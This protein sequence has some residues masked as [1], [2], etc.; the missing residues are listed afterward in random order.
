M[1][2]NYDVSLFHVTFPYILPPDVSLFTY[3]FPNLLP[4]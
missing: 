1:N 2:F 4:A 3:C